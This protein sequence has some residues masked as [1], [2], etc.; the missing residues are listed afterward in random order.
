MKFN[1]PRQ[2]FISKLLFISFITIHAQESESLGALITDRPDATESP[3]VMPKLVFQVE[4]GT[5]YESFEENNIK[6]ENFTYN[7]TLVRFGI[8][9]NLELR[10]GWDFVKE[11]SIVDGNSLND[12]SSGFN[13]LLFGIKTSISKENGILPEIGLLAHIYLPF[14]ASKDYKLEYTAVDFRFAFANT[15]SENSNLSYNL[16]GFWGNNSS[17]ASFIYSVAYGYSITNK[18]G[19]YAELYG[20]LPENSKANHLWDAGLTYLISNNVQLD[21]TVGTSITKGQDLLLSSGVSFRIPY[22]NKI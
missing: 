16:G 8:L 21:A 19:V 12:D 2:F 9:K 18:L 14:T 3:N 22:K 20:D 6:S 15:L 1:K 10:L 17:E 4:T 13:P 7:T 5:F 11:K